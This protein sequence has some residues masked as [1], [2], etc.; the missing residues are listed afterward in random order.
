MQRSQKNFQSNLPLGYSK[1]GYSIA[2]LLQETKTVVTEKDEAEYRDASI[3][4]ALLE[5]L[6]CSD[7]DARTK[8]QDFLIES[9]TAIL[10]L[11][12]ETFKE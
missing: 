2:T 10:M 4:I 8:V 1:V 12:I 5:I 3:L 7:S 9:S 11:S 6:D